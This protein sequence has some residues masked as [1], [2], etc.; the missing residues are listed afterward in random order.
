MKFTRII[1][2]EP[3]LALQ[4]L[5]H[6]GQIGD[7]VQKVQLRYQAAVVKVTHT[8]SQNEGVIQ[9]NREHFDIVDLVQDLFL[10]ALVLRCVMSQYYCV[11]A[12]VPN[13]FFTAALNAM[14]I[15]L[16]C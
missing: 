9:L 8:V 15:R 6:L 14:L 12:S 16:S 7:C 5:Q 3:L 2:N 11:N 1:K 10:L 13:T 4:T